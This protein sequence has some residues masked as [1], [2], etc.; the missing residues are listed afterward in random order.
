MTN[1]TRRLKK[2]LTPWLMAAIISTLL[3]G[4]V[5][6][7]VRVEQAQETYAGTNVSVTIPKDWVRIEQG[8]ELV[9]SKD[10]PGLHLI[11][12]DRRL[13]K[14]A[15]PKL[16]KPASADML[17]S[18]LAERY[19][20]D[21]RAGDED[22]MPGLKVLSNEPASIDDHPGF[23]VLLSETDDDGLEV[24]TLIYGVATD[25]GFYTALYLA[26]AIHY[27]HRDLETFVAMV[28][29]LKLQGKS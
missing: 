11:A 16:D 1:F 13:L 17:V 10:G 2:H 22:G 24:K 3:G 7:W 29:S 4:C 12:F 9:I 20:A 18:E 15:F 27:Y 5:N 26:P 6:E 14:K 25:D 23:R 8:G 21:Y 28:Q 19:I